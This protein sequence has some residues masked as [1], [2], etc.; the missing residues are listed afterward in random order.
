MTDELTALIDD[1]ERI[2]WLLPSADRKTLQRARTT[3]EEGLHEAI[4][5]DQA[6]ANAREPVTED[7]PSWLLPPGAA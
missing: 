3:S 6:A 4:K 7:V 1:A 2:A 5:A